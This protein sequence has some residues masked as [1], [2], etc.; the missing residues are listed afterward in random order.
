[1]LESFSKTTFVKKFQKTIKILNEMVDAYLDIQDEK[2]IHD[3]RIA[4]RRFNAAFALLPQKIRNDSRALNYL[5]LCKNLFKVNT[6]IRDYDVICKKLEKYSDDPIFSGFIS[7]LKQNRSLALGEGKDIATKLRKLQLPKKSQRDFSK[8]KLQK[9][10]YKVISKIDKQIETILPVVIVDE[11]KIDELHRLRKDFKK[12]RYT[13][14]LAGNNKQIAE[15]V[16]NLK[17][18]Q[19]MLGE[20]HDSDIM[21]EYLKGIKASDVGWIIAYETEIRHKKYDLFVDYL[22]RKD[23]ILVS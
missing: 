5:S 7:S 16:D 4:I 2:N 21:I 18:V 22:K 1:M 6:Q 17:N 15:F 19:D 10:F 23:T 3:I 13:I 11:K 8:Q 9:R 12:M 20:I 14:E